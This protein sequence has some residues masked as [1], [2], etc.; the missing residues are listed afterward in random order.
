MPGES[1]SLRISQPTKRSR[2]Y[3]RENMP[4]LATRV[5]I[6]PP[7]AT[8]PLP[9]TSAPAK[10]RKSMAEAR[11]NASQPEPLSALNKRQWAA[12]DKKAGLLDRPYE[13]MSTTEDRR[14]WLLQALENRGDQANYRYL[15]EFQDV[16]TLE[17]VYF[18]SPDADVDMDANMVDGGDANGD[19]EAEADGDAVVEANGDAEAEADGDADADASKLNQKPTI[20]VR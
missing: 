20:N 8:G 7:E 3:L 11:G 6:P 16:E 5:G 18:D 14:E 17:E 4:L 19:A 10:K 15:A 13:K 9:R 2:E 1:R 12:F